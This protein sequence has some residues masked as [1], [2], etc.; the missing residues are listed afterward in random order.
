MVGYGTLENQAFAYLM[1]FALKLFTEKEV[2]S[3]SFAK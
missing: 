2:L 1:L 3:P